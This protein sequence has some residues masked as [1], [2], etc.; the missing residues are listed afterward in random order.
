[1]RIR[2]LIPAV[3]VIPSLA[4]AAVPLH[5]APDSK[6][7]VNYAENSCQMMRR[8]GDGDNRTTLALESEA[9]GSA[10][11]L[12]IGRPL[13]TSADRVPVKFLPIESEVMDGSVFE[14]AD[15]RIPSILVTQVTLLPEE[16]IAVLKREDAERKRHPNSRPPA[17]SLEQQAVR[18]AARETFAAKTTAIEIDSR[19]SRPVILDTGSLGDVVKVFDQ[20]SRDSLRSWGVDP[21]LDAKI[22]R[23]VWTPNPARWFSV[24]DY[25]GDMLAHLKQSVVKVRLL[26]DATGRVT[27]CTS[28]S[29]FDEP[30]FNKIT[31]AAFMKRAHFDP[32]ELADGTKVPSYYLKSVVFRIG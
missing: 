16:E 12:L 32:A 10:D 30:E 29:H 21:D 20:C 31:C 6:W 11:M 23:P 14:T 5:L 9:P 4:N 3:A 7:V 24:N 1:M 22:V 26:V 17:V 15:K 19:R 28:L 25:P 13:A 2:A 27:Q 18:R 8:F